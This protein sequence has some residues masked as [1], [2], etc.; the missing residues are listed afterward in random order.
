[1]AEAIPLR[2]PRIQAQ[3]DDPVEML[4]SRGVTDGLPVVPPTEERVKRM[5][6]GADRDPQDV[7]GTVGPNYGRATVE[8]VAINAVMAGCHPSYFPVVLAAVEALSDEKFNA[9]ALNVTTFSATP[10]TIVNGPVRQQIGVNCGHNALGHGFRANATIGRTLRL[11]IMNIGGAKPQQITKATMGHPAQY[12]FCVGENEEESPWEPLHVEKGFRPEQSTVTLF[13]GHSPF[14]IN[15]H[16]SRSAEQLALSIGWTMASVWNHKN[17]PLFSD[18]VL[19]VCPEH[20]KTFAQDGWSKNDLRQFLFEKIRRPLRELRP[21]VN[22]GEG[23]GVSMVPL[24]N[25][26]SEPPTDDT[27]YP[28]F[29]APDSLL[30]IV[31]GGT[32][33]RFS[34]AVPGLA[35]GDSGSRIT[36]K[37]IRR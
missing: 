27:L 31:A 25:Q 26:S 7:I 16:A 29:P 6:A 33:G 13:G 8:K 28:K 30:I 34:A 36:T 3:D 35:R 18:T 10:L 19:I 14:Q 9:H 20:A 17:F 15:D 12:T 21:G 32:A 11:I 37:E 1:M 23:A 2:S 4:F 24:R 5:L 22:G